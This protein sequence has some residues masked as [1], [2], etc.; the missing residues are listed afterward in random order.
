MYNMLSY[1]TIVEKLSTTQQESKELLSTTPR[2]PPTILKKEKFALNEDNNI[3]MP[4]K[5]FDLLTAM[6]KFFQQS[7][8]MLRYSFKKED[9]FNSSPS[10]HFCTATFV[11]AVINSLL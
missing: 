7:S 9:Y 8:K 5:N 4:A 6:Y 10:L 2:S 3:V 1:T 11:L